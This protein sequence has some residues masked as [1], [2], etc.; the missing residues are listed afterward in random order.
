MN[1]L[2]YNVQAVMTGEKV[3]GP[4][5]HFLLMFLS[6]LYG[7]A[8]KLRTILYDQ[9]I[10]KTR[11]L[12][13]AVI[14]IGN[15][16]VGGTG[17]TPMTIYI[18]K[19]LKGLGYQPAVISRGYKGL[20]EKKGGVVSDRQKVLLSPEIAGDEP[21]MMAQNLK[22]IPVLVGADRVR[23][24]IEAVKQFSPDVI[25][26]DDAFQH[27]RL[28]RDLDIVLVDDKSLFG[29]GYLLPRGVLRESISGISRSD[30]FI[31]TRCNDNSSSSLASLDEM[32][33]GK[34]I[35]KSFHEPYVVGIFNNSD[36]EICDRLPDEFS[37]S[38]EFLKS[39]K[40]FIFS[41]I[42]KN[43]EFRTT[44][45]HLAGEVA[46]AIGFKDHHQYTESDFNQ[47]VARAQK[48]SAEFLITTEK[49]YVK[50]AGQ[51]KSPMDIVVVGIRVTFKQ[52]EKKFSKFLKDKVDHIAQ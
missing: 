26:F 42:A 43:E 4:L 44:V 21:F 6:M 14:S 50:I 2:M 38:F 29:N 39:S 20:A 15:L 52:D 8:V 48:T 19:L 18:A 3:A 22:E 34:P 30:L 35:F 17:K 46:G 40:V 12:P 11:K 27:R 10:L 16:T 49:D 24:G 5:L 13:C 37:Q 32:T 45:E 28:D 47:I 7:F 23:I 51:V 41:G 25:I 36:N 9:G 33:P 1:K 31:L